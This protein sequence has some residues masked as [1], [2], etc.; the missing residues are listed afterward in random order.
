MRL[1][2]LIT[3]LITQALLASPWR[4][5][6]TTTQKFD[7]SSKEGIIQILVVIRN[8]SNQKQIL[9]TSPYSHLNGYVRPNSYLYLDNESHEELIKRAPLSHFFQYNSCTCHLLKNRE[10]KPNEVVKML[11]YDLSENIG[12]RLAIYNS[13]V[14]YVSI[15]KGSRYIGDVIIPSTSSR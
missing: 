7:L 8:T 5:E 15:N 3:I 10:V 2:A 12:M 4:I 9:S 14:D 1:F 11:M 13:D 6:S